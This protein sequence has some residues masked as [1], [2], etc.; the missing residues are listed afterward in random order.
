MPEFK[1]IETQDSPE[2]DSHPIDPG[3]E[4]IFGRDCAA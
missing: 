3:R 2:H 1:L 4:T